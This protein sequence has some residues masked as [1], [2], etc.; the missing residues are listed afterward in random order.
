VLA[1][2]STLFVYVV[3]CEQ[4]FAK[5]SSIQAFL[6]GPCLDCEL[7]VLLVPSVYGPDSSLWTRDLGELLLSWFYQN[8]HGQ[9]KNMRR[10]KVT[11]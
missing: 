11:G 5:G 9:V 7:T 8:R 2:V 6:D 3:L 4:M 1:N 10:R